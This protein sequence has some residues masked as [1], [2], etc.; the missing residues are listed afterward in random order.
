MAV[1][2]VPF[3]CATSWRRHVSNPDER[4]N[5]MK[6]VISEFIELCAMVGISKVWLDR[7][8]ERALLEVW[9]PETVKRL[10]AMQKLR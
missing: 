3:W 2:S 10:T 5:E 4:L 6:K 8:L 7:I 1:I 9:C